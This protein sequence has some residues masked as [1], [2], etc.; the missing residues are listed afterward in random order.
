MKEIKQ[1]GKRA[2]VK[3]GEPDEWEWEKWKTNEEKE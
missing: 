1:A 2:R 3:E